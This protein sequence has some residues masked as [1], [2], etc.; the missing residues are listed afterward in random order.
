M[1]KEGWTRPTVDELRELLGLDQDEVGKEGLDEEGLEVFE[2][3]GDINIEPGEDTPQA[4]TLP[5]EPSLAIG[6][7]GRWFSISA[8][9]E[10][11]PGE[12]VGDELQRC[13]DSIRGR[14]APHIG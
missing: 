2:E 3:I 13:F 14:Y 10:S 7:K 5:S 8:L 9:G 4:V 6:S 12:T 11:R 1:E